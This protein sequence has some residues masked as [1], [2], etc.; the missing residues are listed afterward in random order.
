MKKII[1]CLLLFLFSINLA[2][3][4]KIVLNTGKIRYGKIVQEKDSLV[5]LIDNYSRPRKISESSV[6]TIV[7]DPAMTEGRVRF[8]YRRGQPKDSSGYFAPRHSEKLDLGLSYVTDSLS[9]IDLFFNNGSHIRVLPNTH[10]R[11]EQAP[12]K[13]NQSLNI[14]LSQGGIYSI[15]TE[16]E[17]LLKFHTPGGIAVG[18]GKCRFAVRASLADSSILIVSDFGT[19][20]LQENLLSPGE[21]VV[22]PDAAISFQR[23]EG[24]F[25]NREL[26][27]IVLSQMRDGIASM[28]RY[29]YEKVSYPETGYW[30]KALT[31]LGFLTFF[32]GS[33]IGILGYVNNI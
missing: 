21:M 26:E 1:F 4:D 15:S 14:H 17:S 10:F 25:K 27:P 31:G 3:A 9:E 8:V 24:V 11:I 6:D 18:R 33:A 30:A 5:E 22:D 23:K 19:V 16:T 7:Y 32:Y 28:G 12:K 2:K 29:R 20:G 13:E